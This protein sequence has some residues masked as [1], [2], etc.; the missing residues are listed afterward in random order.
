[1]TT[2]ALNGGSTPDVTTSFTDKWVETA[3]GV[4][5][6]TGAR[7][8]ANGDR[9]VYVD[10]IRVYWAGRGASRKL[11]VLVGGVSTET[12]TVG[13]AGSA[14]LSSVL[15]LSAVFANGGVKTVRIDANPDGSFYFG[16]ESGTGSVDS[17]GTSFGQLSG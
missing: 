7:L 4:S 14:G 12:V 17:Y 6:P 16:R 15:P 9:P 1:M 8:A 10:S 2:L 5:L 11:R 3:S 13:S